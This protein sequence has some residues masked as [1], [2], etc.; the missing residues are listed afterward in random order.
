MTLGRKLGIGIIGLLLVMLAVAVL[1]ERGIAAQARAMA[2]LRTLLGAAHSLE[3][4]EAV[5]NHLRR[6]VDGVRSGELTAPEAARLVAA[7]DVE[8][9]A[10]FA[11]LPEELV[12]DPDLAEAAGRY[13]DRWSA[14]REAV[15]EPLARLDATETA[16]ACASCPA[17]ERARA[18]AALPAARRAAADA[19]DA[20]RPGV[21]EASE[22]LMRAVEA[23]VH[24]A[25]A[26]AD[27][28]AA[29]L[30]SLVGGATLVLAG[31]LAALGWYWKRA[32][33]D[34]VARLGERADAL[35]RGALL[36]PD[37]RW[38][39]PGEIA[40]L[41][42]SQVRISAYHERLARAAER[43]A[44]G[45]LDVE[46]AA[47][48]DE[49][50]LGRAVAAMVA[51]LRDKD[52]A[53]RAA[54]AASEQARREAEA[55]R[56]D[57]Q[58][59]AEHLK[60]LPQP[61]IEIDREGRIV[62]A[63]DAAAEL[64]G[65]RPEELVG[66]RCGSVMCTDDC[67]GGQCAVFRAMRSGR[68]E[69][70]QTRAHLESGEAD[71]PVAYAGVPVRNAEGEIV[72]ALD[73]LTDLST[74][75]EVVDQVREASTALGSSAQELSAQ[76]S[77]MVGT[78][79][80]M[81]R[82]STQ[83]TASAEQMSASVS[84]V[85]AAIEEMNTSLIEVSRNCIRASEITGS[86]RERAASAREIMAQLDEVAHR[87]GKVTHVINDI[88]DQTNLLAL[89]AT[90]EAA[91]AGEAGKGFAVVAAEVKTLANQTAKATERIAEEIAEMQA[92]ASESLAAIQDVTGVIEEVN[93]ITHAIA[94]AV[95]EQTATTSEI[96]QSVSQAATG[97]EAVSQTIV[98]VSQAAEDTAA[99]TEMI[100]AASQSLAK[101]SEDLQRVISRF[102]A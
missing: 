61:I 36:D 50:V 10:A 56:R 1:V 44:A 19:L 96:A 65:A 14:L 2:D 77:Q 67:E 35:G 97:A 51:A 86:A 15:R 37:T 101:L 21:E 31:L 47:L 16:A 54:M 34:P 87:I 58:R 93:E 5:P 78:A 46:V 12:R 53:Q 24:A 76:F 29:G 74:I 85:A 11:D 71:I 48:S 88:A 3:Q 70:A 82:E 18:E 20:A 39:P 23:R 25:D 32:V 59:L 38:A 69:R 52:A 99:S 84:T 68:V 66:R 4:L 42:E 45:E 95:E 102:A 94:A 7:M 55:A 80:T 17:A 79:D 73:A 8:V 33:S 57:A 9:G 6:T 91:G 90:I 75:F 41:A 72:G 89:N 27:G 40:H 98:T 13:Q 81:M 28:A 49:D 63:N 30:R 26:A 92:R 43:V 62:F 60:M 83:V 64:A 100:A 22:A